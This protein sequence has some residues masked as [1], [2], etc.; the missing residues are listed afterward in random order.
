MN[1]TNKQTGKINDVPVSEFGEIKYAEYDAEK[2]YL[3]F[4]L[5][6]RTRQ[7]AET[8]RQFRYELSRTTPFARSGS[9][10]RFEG[11]I[12]IYNAQE[13]LLH[14]G[15]AKMDAEMVPH[16]GDQPKKPE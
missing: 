16:Q 12:R 10:Q 6:E 15:Q 3:F 8:G 13:E 14:F 2:G 7:G 4:T 1:Y 9:F 5:I 11:Q